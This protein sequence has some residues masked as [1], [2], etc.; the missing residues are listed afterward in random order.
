MFKKRQID[1]LGN[2]YTE[3]VYPA[4]PLQI[5]E[6][7]LNPVVTRCVRLWRYL[8][9]TQKDDYLDLKDHMFHEHLSLTSEAPPLS[10]I[11]EGRSSGDT[12]TV[13][14]EPLQNPHAIYWNVFQYGKTD[15]KIWK[16]NVALTVPR[17]DF[18]HD[19]LETS[20]IKKAHAEFI[21]QQTRLHLEHK[22]LEIN[23]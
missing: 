5:I 12:V 6:A 19:F 21:E 9:H 4:K 14:W 7:R 18:I 16:G 3:W 23:N 22:L 10:W 15:G 11:F 13:R 2:T 20:A 17:A 1:L 8:G